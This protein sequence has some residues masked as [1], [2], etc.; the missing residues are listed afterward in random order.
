MLQDVW[1][2]CV[3]Y[4]LGDAVRDAYMGATCNVQRVKKS[5][6]GYLGKY[7][8]KS[9]KEIAALIENGHSEQLPSTW[10]CIT[11]P[12]KRWIAKSIIYLSGEIA[13]LAYEVLSHCESRAYQYKRTIK[14]ELS[15]G[16][17]LS[18]GS[19]GVLTE[20]GLRLVSACR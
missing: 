4:V 12:V 5:A 2:R 17:T 13:A 20:F 7:M 8:S 19:C 14:I 1:N 11:A 16:G 9:G 10:V 18:V 15:G 6:V 3:S